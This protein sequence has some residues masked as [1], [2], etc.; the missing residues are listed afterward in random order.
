AVEEGRSRGATPAHIA[1]I[2]FSDDGP[3]PQ[4]VCAISAARAFAKSADTLCFQSNWHLDHIRAGGQ[5][6]LLGRSSA[7]DR[8]IRRW[9]ADVIESER[10]I[11]A[12]GWTWAHPMQFCKTASGTTA[13]PAR[14]AVP[15]ARQGQRDGRSLGDTSRGRRALELRS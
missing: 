3:N 11:A 7:P 2:S 6:G 5:S 9:P 4:R 13:A 1:R 15:S 12:G 14:N 8:A 10:P